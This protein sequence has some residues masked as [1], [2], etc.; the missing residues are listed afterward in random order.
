MRATMAI[1]FQTCSLLAGAFVLVRCSASTNATPSESIQTTASE[2]HGEEMQGTQIV[3]DALGDLANRHGKD[4]VLAVSLL[5]GFKVEKGMLIGPNSVDVVGVI[6]DAVLFN[7]VVLRVRIDAGMPADQAPEANWDIGGYNE[8]YWKNKA[9]TW[10]YEV[11]V[12]IGSQWV[13]FCHPYSIPSDT[14]NQSTK[15]VPIDEFWDSTGEMHGSNTKRVTLACL[16]GVA[17]KCYKWKYAPWVDSAMPAL[18]WACTRAARA[19]YCGDGRTFTRPNTIVDVYDR[20][21]IRTPDVSA[22]AGLTFEAGWATGGARCITHWR[23]QDLTPDGSPLCQANSPLFSEHGTT[24]TYC[25]TWSGDAGPN[26]MSL[27]GVRI[28]LSSR[29]GDSALPECD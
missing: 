17:A 19:D 3:G 29:A 16:Y 5:P 7:N 24:P 15:A 1:H 25:D 20:R 8:A 26:A 2:L 27:S 21:P 11:S 18:H 6:G 9:S 23:Y 10:L 4:G 28:G 14:S 12:D 22:C 13:P